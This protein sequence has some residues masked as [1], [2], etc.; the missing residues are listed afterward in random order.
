MIVRG[1]RCPKA[2]EVHVYN[3]LHL[4]S[5]RFLQML[6]VDRNLFYNLNWII[7]VWTGIAGSA[8]QEICW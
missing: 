7:I 1:W 6:G 4:R 5:E 2:S 3:S 8:S